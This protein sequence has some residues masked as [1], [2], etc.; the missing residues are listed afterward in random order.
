MFWLYRE[1]FRDSKFFIDINLLASYFFQYAVMVSICLLI[2]NSK[3]PHKTKTYFK[4]PQ[5]TFGQFMKYLAMTFALGTSANILTVIIYWILSRFGYKSTHYTE[6]VSDQLSSSLFMAFSLFISTVIL[7]PVFEELLFRG[8]IQTNS[9]KYGIRFAIVVTGITFG[10]LH[11]NFNQ[12]LYAAVF[13][14]C[15]CYVAYKTKSIIT[16]M[17][18]HLCVNGYSMLQ[19][20]FQSKIDM[21]KLEELLYGDDVEKLSEFLNANMIILLAVLF[22]TLL[23]VVAFTYGLVVFIW[24]LKKDKTKYNVPKAP[25][26]ISEKKKYFAY[27]TAPVMILYVGYSLVSAIMYE[28]SG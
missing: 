22:L 20:T 9:Q 3:K 2:G 28:F 12:I 17:L 21:T 7:A 24:D 10:L 6:I 23:Y 25:S 4:K 18:I 19:L 27:F 15:L 11:G 5:V 13:G 14:I 26:V 8:T 16:T 1:F